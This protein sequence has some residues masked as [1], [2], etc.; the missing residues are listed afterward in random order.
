MREA[1]AAYRRWWLGKALT[2]F[3]P[4]G[5]IADAVNLICAMGGPPPRGEAMSE[6]A[7]ARQVAAF[8]AKLMTA[9]HECG[10]FDRV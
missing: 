5:C 9:I 3:Q 8:A 10:T 7:T 6:Q 2:C 4:D 1:L